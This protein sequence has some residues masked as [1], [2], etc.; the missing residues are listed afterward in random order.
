M[1]DEPKTTKIKTEMVE[2]ESKIKTKMIMIEA[3]IKK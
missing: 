2:T 3:I 1:I